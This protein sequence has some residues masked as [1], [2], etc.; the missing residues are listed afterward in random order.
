MA[1]RLVRRIGAPRLCSETLGYALV[2]ADEVRIGRYFGLRSG[3]RTDRIVVRLAV[4]Q[5]PDH[6]GRGDLPGSGLAVGFYQAQQPIAHQ[7]LDE[8]VD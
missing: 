6:R 1:S 5:P 7:G 3:R 2:E 4:T 8:V